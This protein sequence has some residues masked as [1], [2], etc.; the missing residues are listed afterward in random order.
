[1]TEDQ[2]ELIQS[3]NSTDRKISPG[4][5]Y[6]NIKSVVA[7]FFIFLLY[8]IIVGIALGTV[9]I[10]LDVLRIKSS[11]ITSFVNLLAY[12]TSQLLLI[13]YALKKSK[14]YSDIGPAVNFTR[15]EA[16]LIPILIISTIALVVLL[17]RTASWI[18]MPNSVQKFFERMFTKDVFSIATMTI[19]APILEEIFARGIVLK[20]LLKNYHPYKAILISAIF[21]A[22]LH[23]NPWQAIPAFIG[24]L[25][26]GW[27]YYKTQSVI[28]GIIVHA[29][30]NTTASL[31]FFLPQHPED[32]FSLLGSTWYIIAC[33]LAATVFCTGCY[34]INKRTAVTA[35]V[36]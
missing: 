18:P 35:L 15:I 27:V 16:W 5:A 14:K 3:F 30:I 36:I 29:T 2:P 19:I 32:F 12:I 21:F 4:F 33:L 31:F 22:A 28:P 10:F 8:T 11:L 25:F 6:P 34:I 7:L 1:M 26:L 13:K 17:D 24:G 23:L 20:G 9:L